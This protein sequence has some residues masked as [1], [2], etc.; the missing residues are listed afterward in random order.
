MSN[1]NLQ[2]LEQMDKFDMFQVNI[3]LTLRLYYGNFDGDQLMKLNYGMIK[4]WVRNELILE[5]INN[6]KKLETKKYKNMLK[7]EIIIV[8]TQM[9][10]EDKKLRL[11]LK[12]AV[13]KQD[14]LKMI[15]KYL[16]KNYPGRLNLKGNSK[17]I[18]DDKEV[19]KERKE[20]LL[21]TSMI[22]LKEMMNIEL[23]DWE[24]EYQEHL[25]TRA[26]FQNIQKDLA[27]EQA[28]RMWSQKFKKFQERQV[29]K[30][31]KREVVQ[32]KF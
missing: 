20:L 2:D 18:Y 8:L 7:Q 10:E 31:L 14:K 22:A 15:K 3:R 27:D 11:G 30:G 13:V 17:T 25:K 4:K 16:E 21:R 5:D 9:S 6:K 12:P 28:K 1:P 19:D 24:K 26:T 32:I 29:T 23:D